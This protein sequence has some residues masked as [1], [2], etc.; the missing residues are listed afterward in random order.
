V[1]S[2]PSAHKKVAHPVCNLNHRLEV[3]GGPCRY[4]CCDSRECLFQEMVGGIK[5]C[6]YEEKCGEGSG[7]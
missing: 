7:G 5:C 1:S 6:R 2:H 4:I 3:K